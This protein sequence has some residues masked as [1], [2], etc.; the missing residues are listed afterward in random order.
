MGQLNLRDCRFELFPSGGGQAVLALGSA[1]VR[2]FS[3]VFDSLP[4]RSYL[5]TDTLEI[6]SCSF[7]NCVDDG[8]IN[9]RLCQQA[10]IRNSEFRDNHAYSAPAM[11]VSQS[12]LS[13]ENCEFENNLGHSGE[14]GAIAVGTSTIDVV[15]ST[16]VG[17]HALIAGAIQISTNAIAQV[18]GCL[19]A[20]NS[21]DRTAGALMVSS[22]ASLEMDHC[23]L[24][25]NVALTEFGNIGAQ[26]FLLDWGSSSG[27]GTAVITNSII[28]FAGEGRAV[29]SHDQD[30]L[31]M[32]A[33]LTIECSNV[34]GNIDGDFTGTLAT[35]YTS[36]GNLSVDPQFVDTAGGDFTYQAG[37]PM[38]AENNGCA[39][40]MGAPGYVMPTGCCN[41]IRGN[42]NGDALEEIDISDVTYLVTYMFRGGGAPTCEEE[43]DLNGDSSVDIA[44]LTTLVSYSFKSGPAPVG[45]P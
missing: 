8:V 27:P 7:V 35:T 32:A 31:D 11:L 23:T 43:A 2:M 12:K 4:Q 16:F 10:Q 33:Y 25:G 34:Y 29:I 20:R 9:I 15:Q 39:M 45:C 22:S 13:I 44:D 1:A 14:G 30:E 24:Y 26:V 40:L 18:S 38:L 21:S 19:F 42:I 41:G 3:C 6:D 37:S 5:A 36:F 17:N 28:A